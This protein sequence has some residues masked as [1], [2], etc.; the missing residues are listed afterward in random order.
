MKTHLLFYNQCSQIVSKIPKSKIHLWKGS[1]ICPSSMKVLPNIHLP[2][3]KSTRTARFLNRKYDW[4]KK[5]KVIEVLTRIL[6]IHSTLRD[7]KHLKKSAFK[8]Q[9]ATQW[10]RVNGHFLNQQQTLQSPQKKKLLIKI[11]PKSLNWNYL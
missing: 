3:E 1:P 8:I 7:S 9:M 11:K 10:N 4:N 6:K 2:K 5:I